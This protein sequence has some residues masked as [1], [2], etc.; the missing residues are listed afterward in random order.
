MTLGERGF[1]A[2]GAQ[3]AG[4]ISRGDPGRAL[5]QPVEVVGRIAG[6]GG[7]RVEARRRFGRRDQRRRSR[8]RRRLAAELVR[9]AAQARAQPG[10]GRLGASREEADILALR[11]ARGAARPAIDAG[12]KHA[13]D[14]AAV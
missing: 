12:R 6:G 5:E 9:L 8:Q 1:G 7:K 4:I 14:E 3:R 11:V 13:G 10:R 2:A